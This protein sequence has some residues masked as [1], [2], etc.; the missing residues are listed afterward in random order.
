MLADDSLFTRPTPQDDSPTG[1]SPDDDLDEN[2]DCGCGC[3]GAPD[4]CGKSSKSGTLTAT[5]LFKRSLYEI[6]QDA[7]D[8]Y[9]MYDDAD[10]ISDDMIREVDAVHRVIKSMNR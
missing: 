7:I 6:I 3:G 1:T 2:D 9:D 5:A 4:G 10:E 8:V